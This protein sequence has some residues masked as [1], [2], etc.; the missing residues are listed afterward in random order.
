MEKGCYF[1]FCVF[2]LLCFVNISHGEN[3]AFSGFASPVSDLDL[4]LE[5]FDLKA[6]YLNILP[7]DK[8]PFLSSIKSIALSK[9]LFIRM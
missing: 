8:L 3:L 4:K 5:F 9:T 2:I 6:N 7:K 1:I